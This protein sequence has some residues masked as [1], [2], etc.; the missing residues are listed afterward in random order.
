MAQIQVTPVVTPAQ[1]RVDFPEFQDTT[2]YTQGTVQYWLV[3]ATLLM[4]AERWANLLTLAIE[5]FTAHNMVLE[6]MAQSTAAI[7]GWPGISRGAISG[8]SAGQ[9]NVSYDSAPTLEEGAGNFNLTI[10]G[11]R[12]YQLMQMFGAG[13]IQIG[14]GA[15]LPGTVGAGW[16][17]DSPGWQGPNCTPSGSGF[18]N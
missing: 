5:L 10:Y 7:G 3:I 13:P 8:E 2:K 15:G 4:N 18:G 12:L 6:S 16:T 11:T 14:P 9:V 1:F 17:Q